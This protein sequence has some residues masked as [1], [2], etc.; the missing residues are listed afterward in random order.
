METV[1]KGGARSGSVS[2]PSSKSYAHRLLICAALSGNMSGVSYKGLSKDILAT[3]E[4]LK[5]LEKDDVCILPCGESGS[6]LRFLVPIAGALGKRAVFKMSEGL[7]ARPMDALIEVVEKHGVKVNTVEEG[8]EISG[9]LMSGDYSIPGNISSQYVSG[10]L[11]A[12]PLLEGD[13]TL[14]VTGKIESADYIAM[15]EEVLKRSGILFEKKGF[16]YRIKGDQS[17]CLPDKEEVEQDWSNAAFFLCMGALSKRGITIEEL[18]MDSIQGDRRILNV[19][20]AFGADLTIEGKRVTVKQGRL[21]GIVVDAAEIPDLIPTIASIAAVSEGT[22][23]IIN[24]GRL[25]YKE[26][27][28]LSTTSAMLNALGADVEEEPEG[29]VIRGRESLQGGIVSAANDHRI[30]MAAAV[31]A[32][33]CKGEVVVPGSECVEKSFPDFWRAFECLEVENE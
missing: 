9:R 6:T 30:A 31:A 22:T 13:S 25:R 8:L 7:K 32:C 3:S 16:C 27:D 33:A 24:A 19:L 14:T 12:L 18:P 11:F 15:T 29:L 23:R 17:Y 10:L 28:R 20:K 1:I 21:S 4:C 5:A 26:S 2:I